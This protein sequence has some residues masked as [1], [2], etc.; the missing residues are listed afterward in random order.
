MEKGS[1]CSGGSAVI[2]LAW[3]SLLL[4]RW[5]GWTLLSVKTQFLPSS[6]LFPDCRSIEAASW[7][8][9]FHSAFTHAVK[10]S[11]TVAEVLS[12]IP[13]NRMLVY[14]G[15]NGGQWYCTKLGWLKG[16]LETIKIP[17]PHHIVFLI[18]KGALGMFYQV[19]QNWEREDIGQ[20]MEL[21]PP[22]LEKQ[23]FQSWPRSRGCGGCCTVCTGLQQQ[24]AQLSVKREGAENETVFHSPVHLSLYRCYHSSFGNLTTGW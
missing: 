10:L 6:F 1:L 20:W 3:L 4:V 18:F 11:L 8:S 14:T 5:Q 16:K 9:T 19:K 21:L 17:V 15:E 7:S 13:G 24:D 22:E 2:A 23:P 12:L